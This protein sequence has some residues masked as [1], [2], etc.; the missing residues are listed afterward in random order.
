[1]IIITITI[2]AVI[3]FSNVII[4]IIIII[5]MIMIVKMLI[6]ILIII[7]TIMM[8]I[9]IIIIRRKSLSGFSQASLR[10]LQIKLK[11]NKSNQI[12]CLFLARGEHWST[13][14]KTKP[15]L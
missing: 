14:E 1:M 6:I 2:N 5:I 4:I 13:W 10:R 12:K 7:I 11:H 8:M 3:C 9:I 15:H